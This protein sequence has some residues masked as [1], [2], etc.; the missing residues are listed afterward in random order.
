MFQYRRYYIIVYNKVSYGTSA[1]RTNAQSPSEQMCTS[2][3]VD[4]RI[5]LYLYKEKIRQLTNEVMT[6]IPENEK[7]QLDSYPTTDLNPH[8]CL[9]T[10]HGKLKN[11]K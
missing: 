6:N 1:K 7:H 11:R 2:T 10:K 4:R 8:F 5:F 3:D 9:H